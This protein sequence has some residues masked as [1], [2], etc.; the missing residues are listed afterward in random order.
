MI[1]LQDEE[2]ENAYLVYFE[3][4][5]SQHELNEMKELIRSALPPLLLSC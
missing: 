1:N 4:E 5:D 2:I 3:N